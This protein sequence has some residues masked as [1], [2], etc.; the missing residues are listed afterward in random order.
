MQKARMKY[1]NEVQCVQ[2]A[3]G[4]QITRVL[5]FKFFHHDFQAF[6]IGATSPCSDGLFYLILKS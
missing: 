2:E 1:P 4:G 5:V 6:L 3:S